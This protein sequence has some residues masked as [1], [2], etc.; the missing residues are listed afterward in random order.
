MLKTLFSLLALLFVGAGYHHVSAQV[1]STLSGTGIGSYN[2]DGIQATTATLRNP[3]G[4]V[5]DTEGNLYIADLNNHRI[6]KV[7]TAGMIS[8]IAGTGTSGFNGD[9][10]DATQAQIGLPRGL[11]VTSNGVVIF[12]DGT[13][14]RVRQINLDG[15]IETIAGTGAAGYSGDDGAAISAQLNV[16]FGIELDEPNQ[17][18]YI[19]DRQND[20]VRMLD[21]STGL[22]TTV[23]GNGLNG[24]Q[25]DG[26]QATAARF[27]R[28]IDITLDNQGRLIVC[29]ENNNRVRR[30]DFTTGIITTI[31]GTGT[32]TFNGN[33]NQATSTNFN[34][35][36]GVAVNAAGEIF[37][38]DRENQRIRRINVNGTVSA[39]AGNGTVGGSGDGGV[40]TSALVNYPRE[41][42]FDA[43]GN[44]VFADTE[45]HRIRTIT[46]CSLPTL[47]TVE[48][49]QSQPVCPGTLVTLSVTAGNLNDAENWSWYSDS[50]GSDLIGFG[51]TNDVAPE[52]SATYF[53]RGEGGCPVAGACASVTVSIA[54]P[55]TVAIEAT[56]SLTLCEGESLTLDASG[57]GSVEWS[58][59]IVNLQ[60]FIPPL[61]TSTFTV[62]VSNDENCFTQAE[63]TV[64]VFATPE[65]FFLS[66]DLVLCNDT[67]PFLLLAEPE[68]GVFTGSGVM[69]DTFYPALAGAGTHLITYTYTNEDNC[70][71]TA[72][73]SV[74]VAPEIEVSISFLNPIQESEWS[75]G[76]GWCLN[77]PWHSHLAPFVGN[78]QGGT[79]SGIGMEGNVFD[80]GLFYLALDQGVIS[81]DQ[82]IEIT[83]TFT[84]QDGC[85]HSTTYMN[86]NWDICSNVSEVGANNLLTFSV[87]PNPA[88]YSAHIEALFIIARYEVFDLSGRMVKAEH[89]FAQRC[90]VPVADLSTGL[91]I[92]HLITD[93]GVSIS[94]RLIIER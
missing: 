70:S 1:I 15:S 93:D 7:N 63:I 62:V 22:I 6:R 66:E 24:F 76:G 55:P 92:M 12:V 28:P 91:Y 48:V 9:Q 11:E 23:A 88:S 77:I 65:A 17:R 68:G 59:G 4:A 27:N 43:S 89:V 41:L 37:L 33:G 18:L 16:P 58:D 38:S 83:Y 19:A 52:V 79:F 54:Q 81:W 72:F 46:Y 25:G 78:P 74:T 10:A 8:T 84:D 14:H 53:V 69:E 71:T 51:D 47:P 3:T 75:A 5:Y 36:S 13:N 34:R 2:G 86:S 39:V 45:N 82:P 60:P 67:L 35:P 20:R 32:A 29:D 21:L 87:F 94:Q 85:I 61:G 26:G 56:P 42:S 57:G 64:T 73:L 80:Y 31:A 40:S 30:V 49:N 50:C 44:L 90:V